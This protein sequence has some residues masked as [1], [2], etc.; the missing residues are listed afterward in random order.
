MLRQSAAVSFEH[1]VVPATWSLGAVKVLIVAVGMSGRRQQEHP[2][3]SNSPWL[4]RSF[5]AGLFLRS[6]FRLCMQRDF[7]LTRQDPT[8][9]LGPD[10]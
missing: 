4:M 3:Y 1:F 9:P 7:L 6:T 10:K 2:H 8:N 5:V